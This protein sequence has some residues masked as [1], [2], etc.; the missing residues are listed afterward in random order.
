MNTR[1]TLPRIVEDNDVNEEIPPQVEQVLQGAQGD[2]VPVVGGGNGV[3]V[4]PP[5]M[6]NGEVTEALF[7]LAQVITTLVTWGGYLEW[8]L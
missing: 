6:T 5:D 2:Q 4:V 1:R 3:P 7:L 8:K